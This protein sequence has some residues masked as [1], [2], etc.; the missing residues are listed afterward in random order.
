M[1]AELLFDHRA[2]VL[3]VNDRPVT[4]N[5]FHYKPTTPEEEARLAWYA[6]G[7]GISE[8]ISE[9]VEFITIITYTKV[10]DVLEGAFIDD[11]LSLRLKNEIV[12]KGLPKFIHVVYQKTSKEDHD[13][14][15]R[16]AANELEG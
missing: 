1:K 16:G 4:L 9:K 6:L 8:A 5:R 13:E 2:F 12:E 7:R 15:L 14:L 10:V 11:P 3:Y